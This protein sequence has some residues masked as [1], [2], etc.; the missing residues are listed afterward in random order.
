MAQA[1]VD[2][3][4]GHSRPITSLAFSPD[5]TRLLSG[6]EDG[7]VRLWDTATGQ[8]VQLVAWPPLTYPRGLEPYQ[9]QGTLAVAFSGDGRQAVAVFDA[10][11]V[12]VWDVKTGRELSRF[13]PNK[14]IHF[15]CWRWLPRQG[16]Y[17]HVNAPDERTTEVPWVY[18]AEAAISADG[19]VALVHGIHACLNDNPCLQLYNLEERREGGTPEFISSMLFDLFAISKDGKQVAFFSNGDQLQPDG[20]I[21][22]NSIGEPDGADRNGVRRQT[23]VTDGVSLALSLDNRFVLLG[24]EP[25]QLRLFDARTCREVRC[26]GGHDGAIWTVA[27]THEQQPRAVSGGEDRT[28]RVWDTETGTELIRYRGHTAPVHAVTCSR[29]DRR[30]AS[31]STDGAIHLW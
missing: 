13:G 11:L 19:R 10:A 23:S 16:C 30:V 21:S 31:G 4:E 1:A 14:D 26:F 27:F 20:F 22:V 5:G 15:S 17:G 3:L 7:S 6:S 9:M 29:C 25:G 2:R 18:F 24:T 28:V 8:S 12:L